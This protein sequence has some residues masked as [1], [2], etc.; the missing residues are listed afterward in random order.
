MSR[1]EDI[2]FLR[3]SAT[4]MF[5]GPNMVIMA[6]AATRMYRSLINLDTTEV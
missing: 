5:Q 6:I 2:D 4:Q 3:V 1:G